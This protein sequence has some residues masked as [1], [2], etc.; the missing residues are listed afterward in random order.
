MDAIYG[1]YKK[2]SSLL[3]VIFLAALILRL[4]SSLLIQQQPIVHDAA[5][6]NVIAKNI[7][8]GKG[9]SYD[10]THLTS[11]R[12]PIYPYFL[13]VIYKIF[14]Y[15]YVYAK[16]AQAVIGA[17]T[18][19]IVYLIAKNIYNSF[20][21]LWAALTACVYPSLIGYSSLLYSETL[22][23]FLV[24]LSIL[25]F[26]FAL[27]KDKPLLFVFSGACFGL[28][29]LCYPKFMLL[30]VVLG[31]SYCFLNKFRI[32]SLKSF[33]WLILTVALVI[34]PWTVRN[35]KVFGKIIP[36][37]TGF[38]TTLWYSTLPQDF[39]E[40]EFN[41]EPLSSE[42]RKYYTDQSDPYQQDEFVFSFKTND[43]LMHKAVSNI[44]E[45][46]LSFTWLSIKRF[47]RQWF[48]SNG[49]SFYA[50]SAKI[51]DY[52]LNN[53][54]PVFL[55]KVFLL[56]LQLSIIILG[57]VG[58][59]SGFILDK[60]SI[61]SPLLLTLIYS[62][63]INSIFIT[64]PRYQIPVLGLLFVYVALGGRWLFSQIKKKEIYG[65]R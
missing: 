8:E 31:T 1:D 39:T 28:L 24:A 53:E 16:I 29:S 3:F 23:G 9:F 44:K 49:N 15:N 5:Q 7:I 46:P 32:K 13:S 18:C 58:I 41:K 37:S 38:G 30:P 61:F 17:I 14:G 34:A 11:S 51:G 54:Y 33:A 25:T 19:L 27:K 35:F 65:T 45:N 55:V 48:A 20:I 60:Q 22:A 4:S 26:I 42:F 57:C 50:L 47:F 56:L 62:S 52:Y 10:A 12:S 2:S 36:I 63:F 6:Y 43:S 64:Q 21:G 40:W 59:F